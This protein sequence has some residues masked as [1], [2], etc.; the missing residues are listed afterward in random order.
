MLEVVST[1]LEV[2]IDCARGVIRPML[3]ICLDRAQCILTPC[4]RNVST[5]FVVCFNR[6]RDMFGPF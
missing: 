1:E 4:S 3:E 6:S 5:V 2:Y